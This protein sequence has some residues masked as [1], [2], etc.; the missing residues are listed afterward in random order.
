[1]AALG[2]SDPERTWRDVID[3][4][5]TALLPANSIFP[6]LPGFRSVNAAI[7][8]CVNS[9]RSLVA[10]SPEGIAPSCCMIDPK[11]IAMPH[12]SDLAIHNRNA[13]SPSFDHRLFA[14]RWHA[15]KPPF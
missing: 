8:P 13:G 7:S 15:N 5:E 11:I 4:G 9:Q 6:Y 2:D 14:G 12:L 10:S 3:D 1:M